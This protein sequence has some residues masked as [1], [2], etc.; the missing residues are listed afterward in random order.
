MKIGEIIGV[1]IKRRGL[2]QNY[3]AKE[4]GRSKNALSQIING[5]YN[6]TTETLE[7]ICKA[8]N[9]PKPILFFLSISEDEIPKDKIELYRLLA[10]TLKKFLIEIFGDKHEDLITK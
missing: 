10:P 7:R 3:V 8:I 9:V 4:I 5:N 6:P 1:L 2:T